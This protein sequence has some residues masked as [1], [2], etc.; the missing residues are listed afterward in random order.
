MVLEFNKGEV[1]PG[2]LDD[3]TIFNRGKRVVPSAETLSNKVL[4]ITVNRD[5]VRM[6]DN[7][8]AN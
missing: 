2:M 6:A 1:R 7:H 3:S 8:D 5:I 4:V